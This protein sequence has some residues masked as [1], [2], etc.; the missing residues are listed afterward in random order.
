MRKAYARMLQTVRQDTLEIA[1]PEFCVILLLKA[2]DDVPPSS[3][4]NL[5]Q[6]AS[7]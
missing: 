7:P 4:G 2:E 6:R 1:A 5:Q 3:P